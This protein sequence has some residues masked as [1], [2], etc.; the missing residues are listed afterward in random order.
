M[1]ISEIKFL[2][3]FIAA[4]CVGGR[5][6]FWFCLFVNKIAVLGVKAAIIKVN[7]KT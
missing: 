6:D 5:L 7:F 1:E 2:E 4:L 3:A